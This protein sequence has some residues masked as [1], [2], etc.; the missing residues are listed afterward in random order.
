METYTCKLNTLSKTITIA[1]LCAVAAIPIFSMGK[2]PP[3]QLLLLILLIA[4][5]F[6]MAYLLRPYQYLLDH[7]KLVI[8]KQL[9]PKTILFKDIA[10]IEPVDYKDLG[11]KFRMWGSGGLWGWYGIFYSFEKGKI[12]LQIG[13]KEAL[14]MITTH[15][16]QKIVLSP[17]EI[18]EF[19]KSLK[20]KLQKR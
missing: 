18:Q 2:L 14:M 13:N 19:S 11:I 6:G 4:A 7:E 1:T 5:L 17:T 12:I 16:G 3:K 9:L 10:Q 8:H 20:Q 15:Q